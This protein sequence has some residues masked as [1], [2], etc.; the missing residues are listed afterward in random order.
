[1]GNTFV[2]LFALG[3]PSVLLLLV[4]MPVLPG[5]IAG[6]QRHSPLVQISPA[7]EYYSILD[8][9][10]NADGRAEW[11]ACATVGLAILRAAALS[12]AAVASGDV[13]DRVSSAAR[14][15]CGDER[16]GRHRSGNG[17]DGASVAR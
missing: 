4:L 7:P 1:V 5:S 13:G 2:S 12:G 6:L 15:R 14:R 10:P 9:L 17:A 16:R 11:Q 3:G 8:V